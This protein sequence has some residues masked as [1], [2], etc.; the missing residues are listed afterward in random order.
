M[1]VA[2]NVTYF[3]CFG[4]FS[5]KERKGDKRVGKSGVP[6]KGR[7]MAFEL[8]PN[9]SINQLTRIM[10]CGNTGLDRVSQKK[11]KISQIYDFGPCK[12]IQNGPERLRMVQNFPYDQN[13][14]HANGP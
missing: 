9:R 12:T 10:G 5:S 1:T 8:K 13:G 2:I 7:V 11:R 4:I 14:P 3:L 6:L